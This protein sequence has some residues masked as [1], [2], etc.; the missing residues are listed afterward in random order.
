M[1]KKSAVPRFPPK[2]NRETNYEENGKKV[3]LKKMTDWREK[4]MK[5][6]E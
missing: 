6:K 2:S 4:L 1:A 3:I 5:W